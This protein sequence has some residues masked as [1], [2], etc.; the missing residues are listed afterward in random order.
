M[1]DAS[2][3]PGGREISKGCCLV[4]SGLMRMLSL[5]GIFWLVQERGALPPGWNSAVNGTLV[6]VGFTDARFMV[7]QQ[8]TTHKG[9]CKHI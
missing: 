5:P 7:T 2:T 3:A 4:L 1:S 9:N 6:H 8:Q